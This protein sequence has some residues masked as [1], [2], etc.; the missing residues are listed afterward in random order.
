MAQHNRNNPHPNSYSDGP[1]DVE[2]ELG[3]GV[4]FV[5]LK[6]KRYHATTGE[7]LRPSRMGLTVAQ[8]R[9]VHRQLGIAL[10]TLDRVE[11]KKLDN[12]TEIE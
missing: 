9:R 5:M 2:V 12:G 8:A 7:L 10:D 3:L 6:Q 11:K 1:N 4:R